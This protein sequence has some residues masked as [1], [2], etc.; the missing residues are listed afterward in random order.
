MI[1]RAV[2]QACACISRNDRRPSRPA[3]HQS[4]TVPQVELAEEFTFTM[5]TQ[6]M[7]LEDRLDRVPEHGLGG[8][9]RFQDGRATPNGQSK[10]DSPA[11]HP[12]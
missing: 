11:G 4:V 1:E 8:L 7:L 9:G 3:P 5:T 6:A 12:I 10:P 2:Q